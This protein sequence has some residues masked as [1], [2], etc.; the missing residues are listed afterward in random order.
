M[1]SSNR[2][3]VKNPLPKNENKMAFERPITIKEAVDNIYR[4]HY[5]LPAIQ[6][7]FVWST[8]QIQQLFDSLMRDYPVSSFLFWQ[9]EDENLGNYQFYEFIRDYHQRD[10]RHN[11]QA[12][13]KGEKGIIAILDGQ[14]RLTSMYI[15]LKGSYSYKLPRKRWDNDQAFP[16]RKLYLN[17]LSRPTDEDCEYDFRFLTD[18]EACNPSTG[19]HWFLVGDILDFKEQKKV[20]TY[21]KAHKLDSVEFSSDA[22]YKL[23]ETVHKNGS[24]NF[25]LEKNESLDKVLDIFVRANSGGTKLSHSDLL[26]SIATAKWQSRDAREEII[27]FVKEIN[28]L[29]D[30]FAAD[31]DFV[32]KCCLILGGISDISF[33]VENFSDKNMAIIEKQ[34]ED[35]CNAIRSALMLVSGFG[36]NRETL[37]SY[38]ALI[39]IALYLYNIGSPNNFTESSSFSADRKQI[40]KWLLRVLLKR[41]FSGQPDNVLRPMRDVINSKKGDGKFPIDALIERMKGTPKTIS[42]DDDDIANIFEEHQYGQA[43]TFSV[44]AL[45]YP[46]LDF[47]NKFHQDHI[48]PKSQFT[49]TKLARRGLSPTQIE[50]CLDNVNNLANLQLL[51]GTPNRE[52]SNK[53]FSEWLSEKYKTQDLRTEYM[54]KNHI[55]TNVDTDFLNFEDFIIARKKIMIEEFKKLLL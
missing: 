43:Q 44:L 32:L 51:E 2:D 45:L 8:E 31:K 12:N 53:D 35:I 4:R 19:A 11:T 42:F 33:K 50:F 40:F 34:W 13:I 38:N 55:P 26:L 20:A 49:K 21:L 27:K 25:F 3:R 54:R 24:I 6:R 41:T 10:N 47:R 15:G 14:Q 52:K 9:V 1:H 36:Y 17:L 5:L 37:T 39:P 48:F 28:A 22:L 18:D 29:G 7:E 46:S 23:H 30:G 16:K